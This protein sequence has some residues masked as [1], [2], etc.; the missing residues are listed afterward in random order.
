MNTKL[1]LL[2][3]LWMLSAAACSTS[4]RVSHEADA[5]AIAVFNGHYLKAIND[6]DFAALG[7]LTSADHIMMAPGRP[8]V[9]GKAANDEANRRA[10]AQFRFVETWMPLETVIDGNLAYQRGTFTTSVMPKSG[11]PARAVAGKFLRV[12]RRQ[13]DGSWTMAVDSFSDD[14]P[15]GSH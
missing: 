1:I 3:G 11:G 9:V 12:Y 5:A 4:H 8:A 2:A 10:F 6:G 7:A 13:S 14:G 15:R